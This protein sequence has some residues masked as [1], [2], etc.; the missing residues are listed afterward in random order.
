MY[1]LILTVILC[2]L[3]ILSAASARA[4]ERLPIAAT[5]SGSF[6]S[7]Q[8]DTNGDGLPANLSLVN[9]KSNLGQLSL[10]GLIENAISGPATC[11]NGNNGSET[12]LINGN[13]VGRF[14]STEDLFFIQLS[15]QSTC[16]DPS[17]NVF[18]I[19]ATGNVTGGTGR[20]IQAT[21]SVETKATAKNL[22][23]DP[24]GH[25]FGAQSGTLRGTIT[26]P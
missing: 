3:F 9:A 13:I 25:F 8:F 24:T 2:A 6:V 26:L 7:T 10:Q 18:F 17:A 11:A 19:N 22:M 20:F 4:E 5:F 12:R 15:A 1:K 14:H 16:F 23:A 21:G